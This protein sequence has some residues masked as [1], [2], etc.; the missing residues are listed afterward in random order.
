MRT[1]VDILTLLRERQQASGPV[2]AMMGEVQQI[3]NGKMLVPLPEMDRAERPAVANLVAH[4]IDATAQRVSSTMPNLIVPALDMRIMKGRRSTEWADV[5]RKAILSWWE[6][7]DL[8]RIQRRRAR[9]LV[10]YG[11]APVY[12]RPDFRCQVPKWEVRNPM[13]T[14]P[15]PSEVYDDSEPLDCIFLFRRSHAWLRDNYP[16]KERILLTGDYDDG[17]RLF[18]VVEYIDA[19]EI[20]LVVV[21][22]K[23]AEYTD[24]YASTFAKAVELERIPNRAEV[25]TVVTPQRITLD[26]LNG[27]FTQV[28]GLYENQAKLFALDLIAVEKSVFPDIVLIGQDGQPPQ[29]LGDEWKDGRYGEF[30]EL[31]HGDVKLI[32]L[33][34]GY[35]T[36]ES[37]DRLERGIRLAGVAPQYGGEN[38]TNIRTGRA[39]E[40]TMSAQVDFPIQEYQEI[41]AMSLMRENQ[42]AIAVAKGWFGDTPKSFYVHWKNA[43]GPVDYLPSKHFETDFQRV[44][45]PMP[46]ADANGVTIGIGQRIGMGLMSLDTGRELDPVIDD[47]DL[48]RDRVIAS[49][50]EAALLDS[51]AVL[52]Q[53]GSLPPSDLARIMQ[54]VIRDNMDLAEAIDTAQKEAQERQAQQLPPENPATQPGLAIPGMGAE[55]GTQI[56]E[57][58]PS[59][60]NLSQL[61][62]TL[63]QPTSPAGGAAPPMIAA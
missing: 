51:V 22:S 15:S 42:R 61:L 53:Q 47:P 54:L 52:A 24:P 60:Q 27:Q 23:E 3:Y 25:C 5:R 41:M 7:S 11:A 1:A 8:R 56:Q 38:P 35:K 26:Q 17:S 39:A 37:M 48:E 31:Q 10:G 4:G 36:G 9:F 2:M 30:N 16:E 62:H 29:L 13:Y 57:P 12:I 40:I 21:G 6:H 43:K 63:R 20:V 33:R 50:L 59:M 34:P 49:R 55:A 32:E 46:G 14:F 18:E 28:I 45:Y 58:Q 44:V 19:E